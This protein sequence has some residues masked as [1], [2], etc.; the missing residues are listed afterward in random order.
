MDRTDLMLAALSPADRSA[1]TPVQI[2]KLLFLIDKNIGQELGGTG[3]AF[4]PYDYGP[5]DSA[6]Y[7][8]LRTLE[9]RQL[10]ESSLTNRGWKMYSLTASGA[11]KGRTILASLSPR[12]QDYIR[13]VSD[14]VRNSSFSDLV[15]SI[16][17]A[18]PEMKV[19]S[20]F[21]G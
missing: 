1:L 11:D 20:V 14:Y 18:Y 2:Q 6:V 5:F 19:N 16:Y 12:A 9:G 21:R 13:R 7:D 4:V 10:A 3:F 17:K 15:S 8:I